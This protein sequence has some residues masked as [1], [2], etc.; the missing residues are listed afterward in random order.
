M[1]QQEGAKYSTGFRELDEYAGKLFTGGPV[2]LV[3]PLP[4]Q[5]GRAGHG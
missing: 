1:Q 2:G 3:M 4:A 5:E